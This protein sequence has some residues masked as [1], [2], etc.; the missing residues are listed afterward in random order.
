MKK[1]EMKRGKD[2][3]FSPFIKEERLTKKERGKREPKADKEKRKGEDRKRRKENE[4]KAE[5]EKRKRKRKEKKKKKNQGNKRISSCCFGFGFFQSPFATIAF[6]AQSN[7]EKPIW[8]IR[9]FRRVLFSFHLKSKAVDQSTTEVTHKNICW[10]P[11][12]LYEKNLISTNIFHGQPTST[13]SLP[14][15]FDGLEL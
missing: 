7:R 13:P 1:E 12:L 4:R 11:N 15:P 2:N 5:G 3:S 8:R 14:P 6:E 10:L 9:C